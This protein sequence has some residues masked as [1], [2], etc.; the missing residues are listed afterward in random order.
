MNPKIQVRQI[1]YDA[2]SQQQLEPEFIPL[3]NTGG[4]ADW[5]EYWPIRRYLM[6]N[7]LDEACHYGFF[8]PKFRQKTG[9]TPSIVEAFIDAQPAETDVVIFSAYWD[10]MCLFWNVVE[11]GEFSH[12][13]YGR[14]ADE[15]W[16]DIYPDRK[17]G[18]APNTSANSIFGN[19]FVAR[20][21][22]WRRWLDIGERLFALAEA[23]NTPL[24]E[25]LNRK[26]NYQQPATY[27]VFMMERI[28]SLVLANEPQWKAV[29]FNP[30][31]LKP[32]IYVTGLFDYQSI[33]S[34]A[35]KVGYAENGYPEYRNA[36]MKMRAG[37]RS[38]IVGGEG[39]DIQNVYSIFRKPPAQ[40]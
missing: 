11:Q 23:G 29:A 6:E 5:F 2:P 32:S 12:P 30:F 13:G 24:G 39:A 4:R 16:A 22:F 40:G 7:T 28:A 35:L 38:A 25:Q 33:I 15:F 27:K 37:I 8:S 31:L 9:L 17:I 21:A 18:D 36:F 14:M 26:A 34:D 3:D 20:P 19:Y 10:R 1:F